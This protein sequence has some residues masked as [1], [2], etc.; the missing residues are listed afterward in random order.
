[1]SQR[2]GWWVVAMVGLL[3]CG[4]T[5]VSKDPPPKNETG[6]DPLPGQP[7]LPFPPGEGPGTSDGGPPPPAGGGLDAGIP[8]AGPRLGEFPPVQTRLPRFELYIA[9]EDLAK[10]DAHPTSDD[11]VPVVVVL[12][13]QSAPGQIRY[14]GASTRTLPQKSFKIE[15]DSGYDLDDRDHFNLLAS[16]ND[17][18]KLTEK[19]AVDLYTAMGLPVPSAQYVRVS[20]NG[21]HNGLYVDMEHVGKEYLKH[22]GRERN[23]S[24]YRCGHRNCEMT[25]QPGGSYQGDFEKK[26]NEDVSRADLDTF[27]TWVN[28]SDDAEFEAKLERFVDVEAYLGNLAMDAL[29]SNNVVEDSRSYWVHEHLKDQWMYVPWDLN[30]A[31]MLYWR[32]WDE[33]YSIISHRW[34]QSFT[35]Y[36]PGVQELWEQRQEDRPNQRPTWSILATRVWDRPALR[37]RVLAKLEQALEGP[38]SEAR[39]NAHIDALWAVAGPELAMDP[40]VSPAHVARA[41]DALKKYVRDRRA[42]LLKTMKDLRAHGT[43]SLVIHEVA[44]GSAGYVELHNRGA[45]PVALD[46]YELTADLRGTP[47]YRL[48][49]I[50]LAPDQRVRIIADGNTDAGPDHLPITLSRQG[51]EVGLFDARRVSEAGKPLVYSPEDAVYYGPLPAGQVYGRKTR[52]SEDFERRPI[53]P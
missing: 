48:P 34:P 27:L 22:H 28:H 52:G 40:Y 39:A 2:C 47:R 16:W 24:V 31:R 49:A 7:E 26:T 14:R 9:P 38:F 23:A 29:I 20:L 13:G 3:A 1:M 11:T 44:A 42:F 33:T 5:P 53:V 21:Q 41:R 4:P 18:G 46:H 32:T 36:D 45:V 12:D 25:L 15:L 35:L 30:N 8:D 17:G 43:G 50:T 37:E 51:G 10:L 19:F 6:V